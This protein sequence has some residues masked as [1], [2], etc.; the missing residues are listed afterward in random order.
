MCEFTGSDGNNVYC[1]LDLPAFPNES[2]YP[3]TAF[4]VSRRGHFRNV[5]VTFRHAVHFTVPS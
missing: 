5:G 3:C 1:A 4:F 2:P